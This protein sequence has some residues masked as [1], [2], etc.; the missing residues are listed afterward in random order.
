MVWPSRVEKHPPKVDQGVEIL[1]PGVFRNPDDGLLEQSQFPG[2]C[3]RLRTAVRI[4]LV[5]NVVDVGLDGPTLTKRSEATVRLGLPAT[6]SWRS[7]R[8]RSLKDSGRLVSGGAVSEAS[9][10]I[11]ARSFL[12]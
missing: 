1:S 8:S 7:S 9:R 2:P 12:R 10:S 6:M 5:I 4:E 11:A 3:H